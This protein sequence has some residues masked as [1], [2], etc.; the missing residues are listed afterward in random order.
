MSKGFNCFIVISLNESKLKN[1]RTYASY[2]CVII[3][4]NDPTLRKIPLMAECNLSLAK[5]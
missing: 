2:A 3:G 4:T 5:I 1:K